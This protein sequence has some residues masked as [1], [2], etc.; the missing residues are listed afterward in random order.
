MNEGF[1]LFLTKGAGIC[2]VDTYFVHK[3]ICGDFPV[4]EFKPKRVSLLTDQL[5]KIL[6]I[7]SIKLELR[8]LSSK[9]ENHTKYGGIP[10]L[11]GPYVLFVF[12]TMNFL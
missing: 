11:R 8:D 2:L 6:L 1:F 3:V 5:S 12:C 7:F 10:P 4:K 9:V